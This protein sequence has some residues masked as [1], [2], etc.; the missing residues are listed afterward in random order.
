MRFTGLRIAMLPGMVL[1]VLLIAGVSGPLTAIAAPEP[2]LES[3][4]AYR[5]I[6]CT[7]ADEVPVVYGWTGSTYSRVRGEPD[8]RLFKL[9]GMNIRQCVTVNDPKLGVG[10]RMVTREVMI[11]QDPQTGEILDSWE[12]PWTGETVEVLHVENDPVNQGP[13]F[14]TGRNGK[15]FALP[16]DA[17][18]DKWWLTSAIPLFY[19][20]PLGG[21]YQEYV[22][23]TYQATEMFNFFGDVADLEADAP[24]SANFQVGWVRLSDWLPWMKMRGRE[25]ML[26]FHSAGR[27]L[28]SFEQLPAVIKDFIDTRYP[29]YREPPPADDARRNETS[30]TYFRKRMEQAA[31]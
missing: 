4:L 14:V 26:Y 9:T 18:G 19:T 21:T 10:F 13:F 31:E 24:D 16:F 12:N 27:K 28:D 11:Y 1:G 2:G 20:N 29:K 25:G 3:L 7:V 22:G 17:A 15:P 30:W 8:R 6:Q 23:G 5:R